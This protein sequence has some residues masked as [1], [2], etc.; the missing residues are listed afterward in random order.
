M[1]VVVRH[2]A[3]PDCGSRNNL[4]RYDDGSAYCFTPNCERYEPPEKS[5][6]SLLE[7]KSMK[8]DKSLLPSGS[9]ADLPARG[10]RADTLR[11]FRYTLG[12]AD[13]TP[14]HVAAAF[15]DNGN[16][17]AQKLR[18]P[19]KSFRWRGD[20]SAV[21]MLFG[22]HAW[23]TGGRRLVITEGEIDAM[24]VAQVMDL[25]WPVVSV[26]DGASD[27]RSVRKALSWVETFDSVVIM[28]DGD[29]AGRD[30]ARKI[31]SLLSPGKAKIASLPDGKDPNDLLREGKGGLIA[32]AIFEAKAFR[33]DGIKR[34][35]DL[36]ES[37]CKPVEMGVPYPWIGLSEATYG[38]R[39]G[40]IIG[41][42]AGVG[43]GKTE[44]FCEIA[45]HR[46]ELGRKVAVFSLEQPPTETVLRLGGKFMEKPI[47][48]P[49]VD[50]DPEE[51]RK[52]LA[53]FEE[54]YFLYDHFGSTDWDQ[55]KRHIRWLAKSEAIQDV[56]LDHLTALTSHADDERR[57]LDA[58]MEEMSSLAQNLGITIFFVSHLATPDGTP[59]EEGGRVF[60]K[61]F[62]GSRAIAQWSHFMIGLERNKQHP[63]PRS[64]NTTT[65]RV[66]K[67]RFTGQSAGECIYLRYDTPTNRMVETSEP[68]QPSDSKRGSRDASDYDFS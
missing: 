64:R 20:K 5:G 53:P 55:I 11:R 7:R 37:A 35:S 23:G 47:H 52:A 54:S 60:E 42:G 65:L 29:D 40:Q 19:D 50:W 66:L 32:T 51:L 30:G 8:P 63:D 10:L 44:V 3:C 61:H 36:I 26:L 4:A 57:S 31:A 27:D 48:V 43:V 67:D 16:V 46:V 18:F 25:K 17:V 39:G 9:Y 49:G 24:T 33:P 28:F 1:G 38:T 58:I 45:K 62:R 6:G 12:E 15:D 34:L 68:P 56:F 22:Q 14:C 21:S 13:G 59:H 41:L 2:E